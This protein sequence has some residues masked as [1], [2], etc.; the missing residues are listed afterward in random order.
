VEPGPTQPILDF[1]KQR[2]GQ[3]LEHYTASARAGLLK[4]RDVPEVLPYGPNTPVL[5]IDEVGAMGERSVSIARSSTIW[6]SGLGSS[7]SD[8]SC[9]SSPSPARCP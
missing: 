6:T 2:C 3:R 9:W 7:W 8:V 1:L 4:N 5:V